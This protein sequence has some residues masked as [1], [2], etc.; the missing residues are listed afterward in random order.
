MLKRCHWI[1]PSP[2]PLEYLL[3]KEIITITLYLQFRGEAYAQTS[4]NIKEKKIET[5]INNSTFWQTQFSIIATKNLAKILTWCIW[6]FVIWCN[7]CSGGSCINWRWW[8]W[9]IEGVLAWILSPRWRLRRWIDWAIYGIWKNM[10]LFFYF[11][12]ASKI[13]LYSWVRMVMN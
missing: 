9:P 10:I 6:R 13:K 4:H 12:L 3:Y 5:N 2:L 8:G 1:F 11:S 7:N